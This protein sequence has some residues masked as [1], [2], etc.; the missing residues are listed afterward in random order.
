MNKKEVRNMINKVAYKFA[1]SLGYDVEDNGDGSS[2]TFTKP[3]TTTADNTIE[4]HR[5][6]HETCVLNWASDEVKED[7]KRIDEYMEK[8]KYNYEQLYGAK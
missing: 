6:R 7:A 3:D 4:W 2:V 1:E 8:L 5:S